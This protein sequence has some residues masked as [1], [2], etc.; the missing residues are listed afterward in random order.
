MNTTYLFFALVFEREMD[1]NRN[2]FIKENK[3]IKI[4]RLYLINETIEICFL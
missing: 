3:T 2:P 4:L 1:D